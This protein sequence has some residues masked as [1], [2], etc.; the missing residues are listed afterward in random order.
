MLKLMNRSIAKKIVSRADSDYHCYSFDEVYQAAYGL[1]DFIAD[2]L[3][4]K[5]LW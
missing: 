5:K 4:F 2:C 3:K 1:A